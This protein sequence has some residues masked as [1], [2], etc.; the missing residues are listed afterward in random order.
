MQSKLQRNYHGSF[1]SG[2]DNIFSNLDP[3]HVVASQNLGS[4]G[5]DH[6][7]LSIVFHLG[8]A[9]KPVAVKPMANGCD[10]MCDRDNHRANCRFRIQWYAD[11]RF[12]GA[13]DACVRAVD[14]A[15]QL[16]PVCNACVLQNSGCRHADGSV[17]HVAIPAPPATP[18]P[19]SFPAPVATL[20]PALGEVSRLPMASGSSQSVQWFDCEAGISNWRDGWSDSK[21]T[22]CCLHHQLG[23]ESTP[24]ADAPPSEQLGPIIPTEVF[25]CAAGF[26]NW[27]A[28]WSPEKKQWC[29]AHKGIACPPKS[30]V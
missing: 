30:P 2:V 18:A 3:A 20:A 28:G 6:D 17:V 24:A 23:C 15:F 16:C 7:A 19:V 26:A 8:Q 21:R 14:Y 4:G 9:P 13:K 22:W 29:C 12:A 1:G 25:N 11:H 5:S 27:V 10:A